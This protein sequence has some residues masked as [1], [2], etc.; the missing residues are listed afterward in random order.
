M[1]IK[2]LALFENYITEEDEINLINGINLSD[3][4]TE[5]TRRTQHYGY[6]YSYH[7]G[8]FLEQSKPIPH[9]MTNILNRVSIDA[10]RNFDQVIVNEY[11]PGQGISK[12]T[13]NT[14]FFGD[15]IISISLGSDIVMIF[16]N[17]NIK[18]EIPLK[19]RSILIL[20]DESRYIWKHSILSKKTD[21]R[22]RRGTRIS[23]TFRTKI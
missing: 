19:R 4:N 20:T 21:N 2:G 10:N 23:I 14:T 13:D 11:L 6:K 17:D 12:H 5:L 7:G 9:F 8:N 3:W 1:S 22:I 18:I 16:T 15:T